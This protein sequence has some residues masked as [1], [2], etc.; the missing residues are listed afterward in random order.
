M[1]INLNGRTRLF[2][3]LGDPIIYARSPDWL[4]KHMAERG[5]NCIS[6][7]MEVPDGKLKV[8]MDGL[9]ATG[10][11][12][13][14]CLTMPHKV[15]GRQYC[16]TVSET[17]RLIG[18][19]SALR[20]NSDGSWHGHTTDGD[21][22]V[23]AQI[24]NGARVEGARVL[25]LGA[26]GAGSAIVISMLD[27]G[28]REVVVHDADDSRAQKIVRLLKEKAGDRV[29]TGTSDPTGFDLVSNATPMGMAEGD[30]L[31]LD[32][33]KLD[34]ATFVGDVVAGHG[35]TPLIKAAREA[36]CRTAD[37]DA[38]V[39]AVLDVMCDFLEDAWT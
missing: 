5:M 24:D 20:R 23:K 18:V 15:T 27:H 16:A 2:P 10:N 33:A 14:I 7:P 8:V 29:R 21:A 31:P 34:A 17:S 26:G 35:Q 25:V 32:P 6:L 38:M 30:P 11:V 28:A 1:T 36:G 39:V 37:G 22:F 12:D 4:S 9:A 13:G 3:L 19:V